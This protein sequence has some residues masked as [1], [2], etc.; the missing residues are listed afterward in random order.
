M[1]ARRRRQRRKY[2]TGPEYASGCAQRRHAATLEAMN[3]AAALAAATPPDRDRYVDLLRVASLSVVVAGHWLMAV[4][5]VG[6]DGSVNA[7]N[8]LALQPWLQPATWLLQVMPVFF[9][10]GGFSHATALTS[11]GLRG[12]TYADFVRSRA[13]RLL[14]PTAVF[15]AVWLALAVL[16]EISGNDRGVLRLATHTVAQPLWFVGVAFIHNRRFGLL[17]VAGLAL[18]LAAEAVL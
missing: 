12:G 17:F 18:Q 9:L 14:R 13:D 10:V 3:D 4:V 15:V 2:L 7:T 1:G 11:L 16:V 5:L 8:L 6:Q